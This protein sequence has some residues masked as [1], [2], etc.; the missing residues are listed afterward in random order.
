MNRNRMNF[1][2]KLVSKLEGK[3][4]G[5]RHNLVFIYLNASMQLIPL[6]QA[7][8]LA[9]KLSNRFVDND[10][11]PHPLSVEDIDSAIRSICR[12]GMNGYK[13]SDKYICDNLHIDY[14]DFRVLAASSTQQF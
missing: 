7:K 5:I 1:C 14:D 11:N 4:D 8:Y 12:I 6:E 10:G 3:C 9:I 2:Y 13:M